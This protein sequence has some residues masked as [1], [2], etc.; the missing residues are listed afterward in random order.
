M[1]IAFIVNRF[2]KGH[3]IAEYVNGLLTDLSKR[4]DC[5]VLTAY[6]DFAG[7]PYTVRVLPFAHRPLLPR[8]LVPPDFLTPM[9]VTDLPKYDIVVAN[10]PTSGSAKTGIAL[11]KSQDIPLV[12]IDHGIAP[13]SHFHG[14]GVKVGHWSEL[15]RRRH[16]LTKA[17]SVF[18]ISKFIAGEIEAL[19]VK[20][21]VIYEGIDV[22]SLQKKHRT[23][24]MDSIGARKKSYVIF[25]GRLSR[26]KGIHLVAEALKKADPKMRLVAVGGHPLESYK[27]DIERHGNVIMTGYLKNEERNELLQNALFYAT[28]SQ[29]EGL[30]LTILEAEACGLPVVAFDIGAH[31]EIVGKGCGFVVKSV[32]EFSERMKLL[33]TNPDLT[34][35]MGANA[36]RFIKRFEWA[37]IATGT[38]KEL[39]KI[40]ATR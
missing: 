34:K 7:T 26:H 2:Q 23:G 11:K 27:K 28:G 22:A 6:S 10:F 33:L 9:R 5:D 39:K 8:A 16:Y 13:P 25:T 35:K 19:G 31:K 14:A 12:I 38:E 21:V 1:K 17:D 18:A 30:N 36:K 37:T 32:E 3:G 20:P 24:V 4:H 29:W 15:R 40:I